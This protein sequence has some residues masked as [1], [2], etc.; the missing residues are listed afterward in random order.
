MKDKRLY[1]PAVLIVI[2]LLM[3][4]II[5]YVGAFQEM[6]ITELVLPVDQLPEAGDVEVLSNR[7]LK[8]DDV[9]H[10]IN[11]HNGDSFRVDRFIEGY[12]LDIVAKNSYLMGQYLYRYSNH[13][14]AQAQAQALWQNAFEEQQ[15]YGF[16]PR[17]V[18]NAADSEGAIPGRSFMLVEPEEGWYVY[19]FI[20]VHENIL[21]V[22]FVTGPEEEAS[23]A[24]F[25][26]IKVLQKSVANAAQ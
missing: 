5:D 9:N 21:V 12:G 25:D 24:A 17:S 16:Q 26:Q 1:I 13:D 18:E 23:L 4:F 6:D 10:P 15:Q 8:E 20:G 2:G 3:F 19:W 11:A 7:A 14:I 22:I